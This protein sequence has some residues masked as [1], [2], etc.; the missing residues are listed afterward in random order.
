MKVHLRTKKLSEGLSYFLDYYHNNTRVKEYLKIHIIPGDPA[1]K[2]KK[3]LAEKIRAQRELDLDNE[4]LGFV[5]P[6]KKHIDFFAYFDRFIKASHRRDLRMF[7]AV[8]ARLKKFCGKQELSASSINEKFCKDFRHSLTKDLH[9]ETPFNY[10]RVL[11]RVLTEAVKDKIYYVSPASAVPNPRPSN[12]VLNKNILTDQEIKILFN[13]PCNTQTKTAFLFCCFTGLRAV[14][15]RELQ[16]KNI[17][18]KNKMFRFS[19]SKTGGRMYP[20]LSLTAISLL[21]PEG[22]GPVFNLPTQ[23]AM[24]KTLKAWV[25]RAKIKKHITF[26]CA[27]HTFATSLLVHGADLKTTSELMGHTNTRE[28]EKYTHISE[29]MKRKAVDLI[30]LPFSEVQSFESG[31]NKNINSGQ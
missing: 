28:T 30:S 31:D 12:K 14:D 24:N 16:W 5:S 3:R 6:N 29:R 18:L 26:H 10:F 23:A 25:I 11:T 22:E 9:G 19:Q 8:L 4:I 17:D 13:T 20:P 1:V 7:N 21:G 2:D 27:R 15:V